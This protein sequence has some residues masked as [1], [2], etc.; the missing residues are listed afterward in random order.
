MGFQVGVSDCGLGSRLRGSLMAFGAMVQHMAL[1]SVGAAV[2]RCAGEQLQARGCVCVVHLEFLGPNGAR[3]SHRQCH[4]K[5]CIW[6][7]RDGKLPFWRCVM[8][9]RFHF[10]AARHAIQRRPTQRNV[11]T[12]PGAARRA[13]QQQQCGGEARA[14]GTQACLF[15][16]RVHITS[17]SI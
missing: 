6:G 13:L 8:G 11:R 15:S 17:R 7:W 10:A 3:K 14:R 12:R 1:R 16:S 4:Q 5:W 2:A 9:A